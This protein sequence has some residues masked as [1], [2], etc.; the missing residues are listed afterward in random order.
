MVGE[1]PAS[2]AVGKQGGRCS[3][4]RSRRDL[5]K[6]C[7]TTPATAGYFWPIVTARRLR[8]L[9]RRRLSTARPDRVFF[10][11]RNPWVRFRL[12]LCGW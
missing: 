8:P 11:A 1:N 9:A 12:L 7:D 10:R 3:R 5:G 6:A 4:V 2:Q